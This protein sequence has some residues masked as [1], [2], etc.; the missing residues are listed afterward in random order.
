MNDSNYNINYS[1]LVAQEESWVLRSV[2]TVEANTKIFVEDI[3]KEQ[4]NDYAHVAVQLFA[5]KEGKS[6]FN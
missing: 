1:Y 6:F 5:Y 4:L 2:G 3:S